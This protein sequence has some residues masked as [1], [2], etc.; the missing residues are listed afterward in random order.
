MTWMCEVLDVSPSGFYSWR[1]R[2]PSRRAR[3]DEV[4]IRDIRRSF[5]DSGDTY[6]VRRIWPD[7]TEWGHAVGREGVARLVRSLG[8]VARLKRRKPPVDQG[9]RQESAIAPNILD[10]ELTATAPN[11]KWVADFTYVWTREGWLYVA[12]VLNLFSRRIVG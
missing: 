8:L 2:P 12:A 4:V 5:A 6:G 7:L 3:F 1:S 11:Q 9:Q 10:R